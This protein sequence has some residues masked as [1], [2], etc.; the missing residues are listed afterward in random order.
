MDHGPT[1][2]D[3]AEIGLDMKHQIATLICQVITC[4]SLIGII[5]S[6]K[7]NIG[8]YEESIKTVEKERQKNYNS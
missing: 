5:L 8:T 3:P 2:A 7:I 6:V 1:I 4:L